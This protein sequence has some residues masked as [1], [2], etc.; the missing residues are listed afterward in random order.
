MADLYS[1]SRHPQKE[2]I[3]KKLKVKRKF[4][5]MKKK[6]Y[7]LLRLSLY[8][9]LG[10]RETLKVLALYFKLKL[11]NTFAVVEFL[12]KLDSLFVK[13]LTLGVLKENKPRRLW[14]PFEGLPGMRV[15]RKRLRKRPF[16]PHQA[17]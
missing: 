17:N 11:G 5:D 8:T 3:R 15:A 10:F 12:R 1:S 16:T 13:K 6:H 14:K 4:F 9:L 2:F 7:Q